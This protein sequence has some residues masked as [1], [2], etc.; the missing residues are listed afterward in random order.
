MQAALR[1]ALTEIT[2]GISA[3]LVVLAGSRSGN[4]CSQAPIHLTCPPCPHCQCEYGSRC[5]PHDDRAT[6]WSL[7]AVVLFSINGYLL[8]LVTCYAVV[9][10]HAPIPGSRRGRLVKV[11]SLQQ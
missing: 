8:G 1:T 4:G 5:S 11:S 2:R 7:F 10:W 6:G 9:W 3:G